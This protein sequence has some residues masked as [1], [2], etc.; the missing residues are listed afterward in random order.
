MALLEKFRTETK[1]LD[2]KTMKTTEAS[3]KEF[4]EGLEK[5]NKKNEMQKNMAKKAHA[6]TEKAFSEAK[7]QISHLT[8]QIN[9]PNLS[10]TQ[11]NEAKV[12]LQETSKQ[13]E[14]L[15][16][17]IRL[18]GQGIANLDKFI[19]AEKQI[20][21]GADIASAKKY[22]ALINQEMDLIMNFGNDPEKLSKAL[23][24][25]ITQQETLLKELKKI[26][27]KQITVHD[28]KVKAKEAIQKIMGSSLSASLGAEVDNLLED[29]KL[30][31]SIDP[32]AAADK[33]IQKLI[34]QLNA[35]DLTK[36]KDLINLL[37]RENLLA[38]LDK[39][40]TAYKAVSNMMS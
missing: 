39:E 34:Q 27:T 6:E 11:R 33:L 8:A 14:R 29:L 19:T 1:E 38:R 24:P 4:K 30:F 37:G 28:V 9:N 40:S 3:K 2:Q 32:K 5:L 7:K 25:I 20:D 15:S 36:L 16:N 13:I 18:L 35:G 23:A 21:I 31:G 12:L 22:L 10:D 17:N 26:D